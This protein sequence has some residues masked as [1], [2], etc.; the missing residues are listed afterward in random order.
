MIE[1]KIVLTA[2][3]ARRVEKLGASLALSPVELLKL[4]LADSLH[5]LE[6]ELAFEP[7]GFGAWEDRTE[8]G[9]ST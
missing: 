1:M 5:R 3:E 8:M 6:T 2:E 9:S 4:G 7:I